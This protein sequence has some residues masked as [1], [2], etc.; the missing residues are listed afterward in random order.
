MM[1]WFIDNLGTIIISLVL[2]SMVVG[3]ILSM[4]R[5]KKQGKSSCGGNCN[6]CAMGC[7][8]HKEGSPKADPSRK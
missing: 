6:H 4:R 1:Q 3:I 2:V 5:D 7:A 8:C